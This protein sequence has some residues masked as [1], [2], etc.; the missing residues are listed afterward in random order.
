MLFKQIQSYKSSRKSG[1]T[2]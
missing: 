2:I 1:H